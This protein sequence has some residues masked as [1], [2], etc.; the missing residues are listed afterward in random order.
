MVFVAVVACC[1]LWT[2]AFALGWFAA[3][4]ASFFPPSV[5][6]FLVALLWNAPLVFSFLK[7]RRSG[8]NDGLKLQDVLGPVLIAYFLVLLPDIVEHLA[9]HPKIIKMMNPVPR[10]PKI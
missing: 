6:F 1:F 7:A 8:V 10:L 3:I 5:V 4:S 2:L 9:N